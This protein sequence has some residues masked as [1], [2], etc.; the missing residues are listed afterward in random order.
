M[1]AD[2][3]VDIRNNIQIEIAERHGEEMYDFIS[4]HAKDIGDYLEINPEI[5]RMYKTNP[6]EAIKEVEKVI[7]H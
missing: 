4:A 5:L 2:M 1:S 7:Y 6:N 3:I